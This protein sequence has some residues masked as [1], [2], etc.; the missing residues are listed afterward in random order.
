M[1]AGAWRTLLR[2][3]A[4]LPA[5]LALG[6]AQ[7][8]S[9]WAVSR[10]AFR[11]APLVAGTLGIAALLV[12]LRLMDEV[13]DI[14]KDRVA[15]PERP[16]PRGLLTEAAVRRAITGG[17]IVLLIASGIVAATFGAAPA[18]A[19]FAGLGWAG[20]MYREFGA[21]RVLARN[22][23]AYGLTHQL[24]LLPM[25]AFTVLLWSPGATAPSVWWALGGVGAGFAFEIARKLD[26]EALPILGTY[27]VRHGRGATLTAL[28]LALGLVTLAALPLCVAALVWPA[29]AIVGLALWS[30]IVR[31]SRSMDSAVVAAP[32]AHARVARAA[33]LLVVIQLLAPLLARAWE[34]L[35]A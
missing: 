2:E 11:M 4:P 10:V 32:G 26:P 5:M 18:V 28:V 13:K 15:H 25:Y 19:A 35:V 21:P 12:L 14:A 17:T 34:Y 8:L 3:R 16:L 7:A 31:V 9:S 27:L 6:A 23:F 1:T 33:A 29:V 24:V 22:A 30:Y 20:L